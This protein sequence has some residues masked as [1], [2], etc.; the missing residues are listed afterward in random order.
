MVKREARAGC[1]G[2]GSCG[3]ACGD[4]EED[5][6][7]LVFSWNAQITEGQNG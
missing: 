5:R 1:A 3:D 6:R 4:G 2:G 7:G